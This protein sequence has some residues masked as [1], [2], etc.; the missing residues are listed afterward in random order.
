MTPEKE[1]TVMSTFAVKEAPKDEEGSRELPWVEGKCP[2][3]GSR[4]MFVGVGGFLTCSLIGCPD[5][6][7]PSKAIGVTFDA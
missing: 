5:P 3:C 7:A 1:E 4:T 6:L 2:A